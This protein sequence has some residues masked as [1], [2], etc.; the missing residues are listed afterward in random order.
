MK[1][2]RLLSYSKSRKLTE[3]ELEDIS[4]GGGSSKGTLEA[5]HSPQGGSDVFADCMMDM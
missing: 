5:T 3:K 4:A 1:N 2:K